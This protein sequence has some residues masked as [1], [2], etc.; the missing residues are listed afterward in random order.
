MYTKS[1]LYKN[2]SGCNK[3]SISYYAVTA[4]IQVQKG[5]NDHTTNLN[6]VSD[7]E[8]KPASKPKK[9]GRWGGGGKEGKRIPQNFRAKMT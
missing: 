9:D 3:G 8:R 2:A 7:K 5:G 1:K 4:K 6:T